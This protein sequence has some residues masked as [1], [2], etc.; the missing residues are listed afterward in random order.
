MCTVFE[1][2]DTDWRVGTCGDFIHRFL[3]SLDVIDDEHRLTIDT[4][5]LS[6]KTADPANVCMIDARVDPEGFEAFEPPETDATVGYTSSRLGKRLK[7][8]RKGRGNAS[9][10]PIEIWRGKTTTSLKRVN[11]QINRDGNGD[12][13]MGVPLPR[14]DSMRAPPDVPELDMPWTA[15]IDADRFVESIR[16]L[17]SVHKYVQFVS[18]DV[19]TDGLD[20]KAVGDFVIYAKDEDDGDDEIRFAD[21]AERVDGDDDPAVSHYSIDYVTSIANA[22]GEANVEYVNISFA[23]EYPTTISFEI[24][25]YAATVTFLLAPRVTDGDDGGLL[26]QPSWDYEYPDPEV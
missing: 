11:A 7:S 9:G 26:K 4:N 8:A 6:L 2:T 23:T 21:G 22:I 14:P 13:T 3:P 18:D 20:D 1:P 19:Q 15:R 17:D 24:V 10:D 16:S 5:G 25:D 12:R